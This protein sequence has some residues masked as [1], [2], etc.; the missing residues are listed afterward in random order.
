MDA[1][2]TNNSLYH[3]LVRDRKAAHARCAES[4]SAASLL[5]RF[6]GLGLL[7]FGAYGAV[8]GLVRAQLPPEWRYATDDG[9]WMGARYFLTFSGA[10]FGTKVATLPTYYFHALLAGIQTHAWRVAVE[11]LRAQATQA[12]VMLGLLPLFLAMGIG[13]GRLGDP[14]LAELVLYCGVLLPFVAGLP[15]TW[16]MYESLSRMAREANPEEQP[17]APWRRGP[18]PGLLLLA[19]TLVFA[20]MAPVGAWAIWSALG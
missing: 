15:G 16:T 7:G 14:S 11:V 17:W 10:F 18:M 20:V 13:A 5:P 19:W 3:L 4:E 1:I 6:A 2:A 8:M 9:L 12:M